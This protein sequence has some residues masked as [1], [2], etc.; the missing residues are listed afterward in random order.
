[1]SSPDLLTDR[2]FER[3]G[4]ALAEPRRVQILREIGAQSAP[5]PCS[6]LHE[7]HDISAAT[8]SHHMKELE[9][10]GLVSIL[11]E[12]RCASLSL[13]REVLDAYLARLARI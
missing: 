12:G 11:R 13:N 1:M 9:T 5:L 7:N 3:I 6:A 10:A 2:Q 8:L 4:R